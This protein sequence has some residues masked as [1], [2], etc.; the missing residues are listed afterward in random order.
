M[1]EACIIH[2]EKGEERRWGLL[3]QWLG[4]VS[5][6]DILSVGVG[7]IVEHALG[8]CMGLCHGLDAKASKHGIG[9]PAA[10]ELNGIFVNLS[11]QEGG[12]TAWTEAASTEKGRL[13]ASL[14]L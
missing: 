5:S 14:R 11:T 1:L 12:G 9:F 13:N 6:V 4:V 2:V 7:A 3:R 10:Q 8:E